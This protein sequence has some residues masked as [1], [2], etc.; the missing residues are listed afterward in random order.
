M[1]EGSA[2]EKE[3]LDCGAVTITVPEL[4]EFV[5]FRLARLEADHHRDIPF[6][7]AISSDT[8]ALGVYHNIWHEIICVWARTLSP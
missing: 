3:L 5:K 4:S 6:N 1:F 8:L 7:E 2:L